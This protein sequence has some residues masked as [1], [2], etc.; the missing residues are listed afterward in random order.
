V[1]VLR[2]SVLTSYR[3]K[4]ISRLLALRGAQVSDRKV[5]S[6]GLS[7]EADF[8]SAALHTAEES[9]SAEILM[10]QNREMHH[11]ENALNRLGDGTYGF[12]E[13]CSRPIP[14]ER[15][16]AIPYAKRCV[17]CQREVE[18]KWAIWQLV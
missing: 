5:L 8:I 2:K 11:V 1:R 15:L 7:R 18:R 16:D 12:C 10:V 14:L 3:Q 17:Q 13:M 4:L 9:V 6:H